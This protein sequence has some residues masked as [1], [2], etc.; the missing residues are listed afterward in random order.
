MAGSLGESHAGARAD[1]S[2]TVT[3]HRMTWLYDVLTWAEN[4]PPG[5]RIT[6]IQCLTPLAGYPAIYPCE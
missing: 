4:T 3:V 1:P 5:V 2:L 6:W